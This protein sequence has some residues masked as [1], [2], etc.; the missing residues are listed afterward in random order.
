MTWQGRGTRVKLEDINKVAIYGAG[1]G[2][3]GRCFLRRI[4]VT[5]FR[6]RRA[7]E[8]YGWPRLFVDGPAV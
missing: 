4:S 5:M 8:P 3:G 6:A 7:L 1:S 2:R